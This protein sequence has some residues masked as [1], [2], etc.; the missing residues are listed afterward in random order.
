MCKNIGVATNVALALNEAM[1][2]EP[3]KPITINLEKMEV[4]DRTFIEGNNNIIG[5]DNSLVSL[6]N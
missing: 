6:T 5:N 4:G 2:R 3:D 1:N